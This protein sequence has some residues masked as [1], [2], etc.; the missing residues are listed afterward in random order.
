AAASD[1]AKGIAGINWYAQILPVRVLGSCGGSNSDILEGMQWAAGLPVPGVPLN[2]NPARVINMSLGGKGACD[3]QYQSAIDEVLA[4]GVFIAVA[5]GN[6]SD[7]IEGYSPAGCYGVSTVAATDPYGFLA[8]YSNYSVYV[9]IAAPG[10]DQS[11][12]GD[13]WGIWSTA[14]TG[15]K[16][17]EF[18]T[19][20]AYNGT[21]Q[22]T[23]HVA[24]VASLMLS[25]NPDL[26]PAQIKSIMADTSS[27][28]ATTSICRTTGACGAGIVNAF[29]AIKEV[30]R[31]VAVPTASVIEYYNATLDHYFVSAAPLEISALDAGKFPG[32]RRTG[33]SFNAYARA[34]GGTSPVCRFYLPPSY[35]D[36]HFFSASTVECA[37]VRTQFPYFAYEAPDVFHIDLPST[38]GA[39]PE[40]DTPV[41]RLWNQRADT[42]HR[43]TTSIAIRNQ[44][45]AKGYYAEGYGPQAVA[46]CAVQ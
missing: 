44:M 46:M 9:D 20:L 29:Y 11:R 35:G 40:G 15:S 23:P 14:N 34:T 42:N 12:Y 38:V 22:A 17:P 18:A 28:F 37:K 30:V 25:I 32:W 4:Q 21:S 10:G 13:R 19:Y 45:L 24:G 16:G 33:Q 5:A 7:D 39:C 26:T 27:Y 1:N 8:S 36:S 31:Q 43:Y 6:E 2:Q 41:Y 3:E